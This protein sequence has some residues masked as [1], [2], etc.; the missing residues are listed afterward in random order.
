[1]PNKVVY[2]ARDP[3]WA[4]FKANPTVPKFEPKDFEQ[5]RDEFVR[6]TKNL[7][8]QAKFT[9]YKSVI[10][11]HPPNTTVD[12]C[13]EDELQNLVASSAVEFQPRKLVTHCADK[14]TAAL[15]AVSSAPDIN[16]VPEWM[17]SILYDNLVA[18]CNAAPDAMLIIESHGADNAWAAWTDINRKFAKVGCEMTWLALD[19]MHKSNLSPDPQDPLAHNR[20]CL[21]KLTGLCGAASARD[22]AIHTYAYLYQFNAKNEDPVIAERARDSEVRERMMLER[23]DVTPAHWETTWAAVTS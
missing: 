11:A 7:V 15:T 4:Y 9:E 17:L 16:D 21:A 14:F 23:K 19:D 20:A 5:W 1:M 10:E 12:Q 22:E 3:T 6:F 13:R 2:P 18:A 8:Q